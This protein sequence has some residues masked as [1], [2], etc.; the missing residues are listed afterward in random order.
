MK[1]NRIVMGGA[2][3]VLI[4]LFFLGRGKNRCGEYRISVSK[5]RNI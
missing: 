1:K 4:L 3:I 2:V 5:S